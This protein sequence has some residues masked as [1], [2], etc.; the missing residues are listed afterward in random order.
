[1]GGDLA[2]RLLAYLRETLGEPGL[3]FAEH[4]RRLTGGFDTQIFAFSL[5]GAP[6]AFVHPLI[7]RLLDPQHDP[8]RALRERATHNALVALG[9]A[10]PRVVLASTEARWLGAAFLIMER[11]AGKPLPEVALL[12][13]ARIVAEL[14][15]RLHA[16]D[17]EAFLASLAREGMALESFTFDA[18]LD[19]LAGRVA[20]TPLAGLARGIDWLVERRPAVAGPRAICHGDFHPYNILMAAG[21]VTGVLDWP[22]AIV[23]D[24]AF[25]VASTLVI[26]KL[27]PMNV[28]DLPAGV[29]WLATVARP[30]LVGSYRRRYGRHRELDQEKLQYYEAAACMKA[31]VKAAELRRASSGSP[32][33]NTLF[34]STFT[35]RVVE[36]FQ[37]LTGITPILP[38][39]AAPVA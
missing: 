18:Y 11:L 39:V 20:R 3:A 31:L 29:R 32:E 21:R 15:A 14:Q 36:H 35:D 9:Y 6:S 26:L 10:A 2:T 34:A 1:V 24:P 33:A 25:D 27:V 28:S 23:A 13:M 4:P 16:L 8:T 22:H 17:S 5:S 38:T 7:L 30:L 37:R 12:G 19:Q